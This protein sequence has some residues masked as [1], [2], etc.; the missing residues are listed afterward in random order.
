MAPR[1]THGREISDNITLIMQTVIT[2]YK[3]RDLHTFGRKKR[4]RVMLD[5]F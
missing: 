1:K 3:T 5:V 4:V 2:E